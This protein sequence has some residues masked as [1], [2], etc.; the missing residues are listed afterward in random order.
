MEFPDYAERFFDGTA[1]KDL[2]GSAL[3]LA[4]QVMPQEPVLPPDRMVRITHDMRVLD[5][6]RDDTEVSKT[7]SSSPFDYT[8]REQSGRFGSFPQ[9]DDLSAESTP[10]SNNPDS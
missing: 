1:S 5:G 2:H 3:K 7:S 9:H 6:S 8:R 4:D 10:E